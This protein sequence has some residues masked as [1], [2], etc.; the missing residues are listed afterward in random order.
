M[1]T[2]PGSDK[3][4]ETAGD[5]R[6]SSPATDQQANK[7][8]AGIRVSLACVP[9]RS[10]HIKCDATMPTCLR[11]QAEHKPCFYAKSRRGIRDAKK[12]SMIADKLPH[13]ARG[14]SLWPV[15]Q[16]STVDVPI[17]FLNN[18]MPSGWSL[19][20]TLRP[21]SSPA[22][23]AALLL[24]AFYSRCYA[25]FPFLLPK[26]YMMSQ[27]A[28]NA[29]ELRFL[30]SVCIYA[31]S[32]YEPSISSDELREA[33]Y[34]QSF[35]HLPMTAFTVQALALLSYTAIGEDKPELR[36]IWLDRAMQVAM[37]I[38]MQHRSFAE[39]EPD[40]VVAESYRRTWWVLYK[41]DCIRATYENLQTFLLLSV[42]A[43]VDLPCEEWEYQSGVSQPANLNV[44]TARLEVLIRT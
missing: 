41:S 12:R 26:P 43:T 27:L 37:D 23:A 44:Q 7:S 10:K 39:N 3:S 28:K 6:G 4:S 18:N 16:L 22:G 2:S 35:G 32:L 19:T 40:V 15:S 36:S 25:N 24:D 42:P 29:T 21:T 9:C 14:P 20:R 5:S 34:N 31:A 38:G 33:V 11:C 17:R 13:S 30:V 1:S 8:K